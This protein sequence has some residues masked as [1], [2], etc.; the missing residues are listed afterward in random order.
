VLGY[1][2]LLGSLFS[3]VNNTHTRDE[4]AMI[5]IPYILDVPDEKISTYDLMRSSLGK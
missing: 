1:I 3:T 5:V 2:P 4:V